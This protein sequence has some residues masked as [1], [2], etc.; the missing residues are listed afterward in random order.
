ML[1]FLENTV[2]Y[3]RSFQS[4]SSVVW[5][6][7]HR[8]FMSNSGTFLKDINLEIVHRSTYDARRASRGI[9][10]SGRSQKRRDSPGETHP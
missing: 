7:K 10:M 2:L 6:A 1:G 4:G 9:G 8:I 5:T 3:S